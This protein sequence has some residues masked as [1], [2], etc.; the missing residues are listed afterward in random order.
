VAAVKMM[1]SVVRH[2]ET[3]LFHH[4]AF[5]TFHLHTPHEERRPLPLPVDDAVAEATALLSRQI[6]ARGIVAI[7]RGGWSIGV[8]SAARPA[9]PLLGVSADPR[10]AR[11]GCLLWGVV[12]TLVAPDAMDDLDAL[13]RRLAREAGVATEGQPILVVRGLHIEPSRSTPSIGVLTV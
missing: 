5:A 2:T 10:I 11:R 4:G 8:M 7:S 13:A 3:Y 12:P 1:D 6:R 9:A